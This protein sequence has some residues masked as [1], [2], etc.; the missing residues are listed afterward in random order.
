MIIRYR[1][2]YLRT[3]LIVGSLYLLAGVAGIIVQSNI[4]NLV[5]NVFFSLA[6]FFFLSSYYYKQKYQYLKLEA[7]VLTC[8]I[9]G[10]K[11]RS[12]DLRQVTSIKKFTDEITF[13]TPHK[14]LKISTKLIA[15]EDLPAFKAVMT[16]LDLKPE[17]NPFTEPAE[18]FDI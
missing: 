7:G 10:S 5:I 11:N 14:K 18:K 9:F 4:Y 6:G 1:K 17:K 8:Y 3:D 15:K 16:S 2:R 13:L 12:I